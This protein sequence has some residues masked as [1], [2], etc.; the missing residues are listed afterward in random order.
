M[1]PP[2]FRLPRLI[3]FKFKELRRRF[4]D[5]PFTLLDVGAGNHSATVAKRWFPACR[6][7][8]VDRDRDYNNGPED[9]AAMEGF[10]ELDLTELRFEA[11]P[12]GA[13]DV[14]VMAHVVEHL[15][16]GVDVVRALVPKLRPGGF[17]YLEF[18]SA[19]SLH[20][21]S[22]R[23]TLNFWDDDTHVRIYTPDELGRALE[24]EGLRVVRSGARRD[25]VRAALTPLL[26]LHAKRTYGF[27][28]GG[29]LW[30]LFGFADLVVAEKPAAA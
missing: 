21:P 28:P 24:A 29:V 20:F 18:P 10:Y 13:F 4:G 15:R 6:Y 9:F 8:G 19:R 12:D 27:V 25:P 16:N 23:G 3:P 14:I 11:I 30:D 2:S 17:I 26:A 1:S 22:M 7:Y 5:R